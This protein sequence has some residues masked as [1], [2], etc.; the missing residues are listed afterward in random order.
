MLL[1]NTLEGAV[2]PLVKPTVIVMDAAR[3]GVRDSV[4]KAMRAPANA[5]D[6]HAVQ[7]FEEENILF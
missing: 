1:V 6:C 4:T 5:A 7:S 2:P 3:E